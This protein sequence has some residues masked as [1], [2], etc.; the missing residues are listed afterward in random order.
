MSL[1]GLKQKEA[2]IKEKIAAIKAKH[3]DLATEQVELNSLERQARVYEQTATVLLEKYEEMSLLK[4]MEMSRL[5]LIAKAELP[6]NPAGLPSMVLLA[7]G[8]I[9][10]LGLG[11]GIAFLF[12]YLDSSI[13]RKGDVE[14]YLALP[15]IG[16]IPKMKAFPVPKNALIEGE[17]N[18]RKK[19]RQLLS[20][21]LLFDQNRPS[22]WRNGA[23]K[24]AAI[25]NYRT[26]AVQIRYANDN[27]PIKTLLIASASPDEGKTTVATNL[28]ISLAQTGKK[29][30]LI[31]ADVRRGQ[32]HQ[33]FRQSESPGLMD[34][35]MDETN[36]SED[37]S[38]GE[39]FIR[40]TRVDNLYI[41][42][43][44][45][46]VPNPEAFLSSEKM[47]RLIKNLKEEYDIILFDSPA[48]LAAADAMMLAPHVDGALLVVR[49][50]VTQRQMALRAIELLEN[51]HTEI[52]GIV[53]NG[54]NSSRQY[55]GY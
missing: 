21:I 27:P 38:L 3:P 42:P 41:L 16:V 15:T 13:K 6:V 20:H 49:S 7:L 32:I 26:L 36:F 44:G 29:L 24:S 55:G 31:D 18:H 11:V 43:S 50:G 53:L 39:P 52:R 40:R 4:E 14:K 1:Q 10:G 45:A 46:Q 8:G 35:L 22:I 51:I 54:D 5:Q 9:F 37:A 19:T 47:E 28:A 2:L 48:L 30:L 17:G 25:S 12:A 34:Y 23:G 33:I